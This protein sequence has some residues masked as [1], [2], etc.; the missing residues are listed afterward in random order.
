MEGFNIESSGKAG[1][2]PITHGNQKK[3]FA[4]SL[5]NTGRQ[6]KAKNKPQNN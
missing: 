6:N 1:Q 5:S 2:A 3:I 4:K